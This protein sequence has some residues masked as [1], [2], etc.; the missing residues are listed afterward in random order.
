[1]DSDALCHHFGIRLVSVHDTS[2]FHFGKKMQVSMTYLH[3]MAFRPMRPG[4]QCLRKESN[5]LGDKAHDAT[6]EELGFKGCRQTP[7][8]GFEAR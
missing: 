1:M 2:S 8:L 6:Y 7:C 4:T 5:I 3:T